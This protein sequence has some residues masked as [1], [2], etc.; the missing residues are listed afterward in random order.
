MEKKEGTFYS[1]IFFDTDEEKIDQEDP[2]DDCHEDIS[3][4][5]V[6]GEGRDG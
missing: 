1:P 6:P 3:L 4:N 5:D 2:L